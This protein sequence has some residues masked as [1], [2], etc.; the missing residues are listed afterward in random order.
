MCINKLF[1]FM[2][3]P[4]KIKYGHSKYIDNCTNERTKILM[5]G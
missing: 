4:L 5:S 3:K 2:Y 1:N